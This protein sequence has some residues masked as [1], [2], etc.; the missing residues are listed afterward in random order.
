MISVVLALLASLLPAGQEPP[1]HSVPEGSVPNRPSPYEYPE[2]AMARGVT[3]GDVVVD[4][5]VSPTG[6]LTDCAIVSEEPP[7]M[8]FGYA[9]L[10]GARRSR[11]DPSKATVVEGET[12]I[13]VTT[14][15]RI[16][17]PPAVPEGTQGP[18]P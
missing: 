13:S 17:D 1:A 11:I 9:A 4:C 5:R 8:G 12:R 10:A 16:S 18:P 6:A 2:R 3:S 15:F 14:R 7:G